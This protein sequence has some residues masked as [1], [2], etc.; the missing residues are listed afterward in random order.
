MQPTLKTGSAERL[1]PGCAI[2]QLVNRLRLG[3]RMTD[4]VI[5]GINRR[6]SQQAGNYSRIKHGTC[7]SA[8]KR[9]TVPQ[10]L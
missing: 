1:L 8:A 4:W 3:R 2:P 10:H 7:A 6:E 5:A 9:P